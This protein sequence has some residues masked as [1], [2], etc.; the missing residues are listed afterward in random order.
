MELLELLDLIQKGETSKVQFKSTLEHI[1]QLAQEMV[2]FSNTEGGVLIIGVND[3]G[4][5]NGL[6]KD[7]IHKFNQWISNAS[8]Q[9]IKPPISPLT[10]IFTI[11]EKNILVV[12]VSKGI[13]RPYYTHEG[14]AYVKMGADKR[15]A[16]PEEILRMFQSSNKIY[17]DETL[18][19]SSNIND[20][21]ELLLKELIFNKYP[22]KYEAKRIRNEDLKNLS[23]NSV[24]DVIGVDT[25]LKNILQNMV[26]AKD[27]QLT[28]GGLLLIGKNPQQFRQLFT[29]QCIAFVGNDISSTQFR[30]KEPPF[31]G[32]L[33][34][35]FESTMNFLM[36]NL[37]KVQL[38][39]GFNIAGSLE[40]PIEV[41]EELVIN[42]LIHRDYF[43]NS[44]INIFIFD[45]RI[46]IISPG[47]LPNSLTEDNIK[48]GTSIVR[49]PIIYSNARFL[50]IPFTGIGSGIPR[51]L[52]LYPDIEFQNIVAKEQFK[53]I[54]YRNNPNRL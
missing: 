3:K 12:S 39:E 28:L 22:K 29:V 30:D 17:A 1:N 25:P 49:N 10:D 52:D 15:I 51:A 50:D 34:T 43:I 44:T 11:D 21:D 23:L 26:F 33:K 36:R 20:I 46:E 13:N 19:P 8:S 48:T 31:D 40:I 53:A 5:I 41:L 16:P 32:S 14:I 35:L 45:N 37:K 4:Q 9:H 54:I 2:A 38:N 27:N 42:S 18:I 47:K 7:E 6:T 24:I